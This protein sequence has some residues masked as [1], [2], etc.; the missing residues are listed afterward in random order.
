MNTAQRTYS[1]IKS[2]V[3]NPDYLIPDR[4]SFGTQ[5]GSEPYKSSTKKPIST[6]ID[7]EILAEIPKVAVAPPI[8][9]PLK[10]KFKL[11]QLWEGRV[12]DTREAE[13]DAIITNKTNPNFADELVTID[14]ME[15][16]PDDFHLVK[17]GSV[18]YWSVGFLDY[19]GRGRA[20][21]SKIRFR[22]LKGWTKKEIEHSKNIGKKFAEYFESNSICSSQT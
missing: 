5:E 21:E 19:P 1:L 8:L 13:I 6:E 7:R 12:V 20:R 16:T 10:G 15:I 14:I 22:R 3:E 2:D 17:K 18:F 11:L 9:N 4:I